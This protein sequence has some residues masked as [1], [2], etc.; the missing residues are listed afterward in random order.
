M[1]LRATTWI[2]GKEAGG[3]TSGHE[4][5]EEGIVAS[6][7]SVFTHGKARTMSFIS[8]L[9][10]AS[11]L[12]IFLYDVSLVRDLLDSCRFIRVPRKSPCN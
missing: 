1:T 8:M 4:A 10:K 3:T 12:Q 9:S 7:R 11:L 2:D 6:A 5:E